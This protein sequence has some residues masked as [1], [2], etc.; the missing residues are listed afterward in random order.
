MV[1]QEQIKKLL[2]VFTDIYPNYND[3][4]HACHWNGT[5]WNIIPHEL[6]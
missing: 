2:H 3:E 4:T 6:E 1:I 5:E